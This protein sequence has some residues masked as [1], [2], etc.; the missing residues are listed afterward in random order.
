MDIWDEF[1]YCDSEALANIFRTIFLE[2]DKEFPNLVAAID[3][4]LAERDGFNTVRLYVRSWTSTMLL[5]EG[6]LLRKKARVIIEKFLPVKSIWAL[7]ALDVSCQNSKGRAVVIESCDP[8]G[9]GIWRVHFGTRM[10][11]LKHDLGNALWGFC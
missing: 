2:L 7:P 4:D 10:E 8:C 1:D 11:K 3:F 6:R 5:G 9:A